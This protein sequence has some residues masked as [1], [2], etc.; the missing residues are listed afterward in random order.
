M[1]T[2]IRGPYSVRNEESWLYW[3]RQQVVT[4]EV[5][6]YVTH[7]WCDRQN[8]GKVALANQLPGSRRNLTPAI[9]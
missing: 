6:F 9:N 3:F 2:L 1:R 7:P 5:W 4:T 8:L